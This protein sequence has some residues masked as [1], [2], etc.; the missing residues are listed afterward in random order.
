M[1]CL[2]IFTKYA[3]VVPIKSKNEGD[4]A[5]GIFE[6]MKNMLKKPKIIYTGDEKV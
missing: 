2:D 1:I 5:A 6:C 4:V 3:T